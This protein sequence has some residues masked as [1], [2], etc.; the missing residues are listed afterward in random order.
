MSGRSVPRNLR[1]DRSLDSGRARQL[2]LCKVDG[3]ALHAATCVTTRHRTMWTLLLVRLQL[4]NPVD[5]VAIC[6]KDLQLSDRISRDPVRPELAELS[7]AGWA[8]CTAADDV[9]YAYLAEGV[10]LGTA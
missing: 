7:S 9:L 3:R 4:L 2:M 5:L 10:A 6:T 8:A 1:A